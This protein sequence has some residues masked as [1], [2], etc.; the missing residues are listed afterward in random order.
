M[1]KQISYI[2]LKGEHVYEILAA[3]RKQIADEKI[4]PKVQTVIFV[5]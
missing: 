2:S 3:L 5:N 4:K 1:T